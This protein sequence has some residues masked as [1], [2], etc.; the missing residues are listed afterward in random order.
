MVEGDGTGKRGAL[1][2][3]GAVAGIGA[4]AGHAREKRAAGER[5]EA[6]RTELRARPIIAREAARHYAA[7]DALHRSFDANR[8]RFI[9]DSAEREATRIAREQW[10]KE[11][12]PTQ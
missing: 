10:L 2:V 3:G 6:L 5:G 12:P 8:L 4:L 1:G 7:L 9:S 11:H